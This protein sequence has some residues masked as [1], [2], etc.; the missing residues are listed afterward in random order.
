MPP[1]ST[2]IYSE[3]L[4]LFSFCLFPT[5]TSLNLKSVVFTMSGA[6]STPLTR[7]TPPTPESP[8]T[9]STAL[10]KPTVSTSTSISSVATS[11]ASAPADVVS[12]PVPPA[13]VAHD[14]AP[15]TKIPRSKK[16]QWFTHT[17]QVCATLIATVTTL[18][19][20]FYTVRT[21]NLGVW[22]YDLAAWTANKDYCEFQRSFEASLRSS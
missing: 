10:P 20:I 4:V 3:S 7:A 19:V 8:S 15:S 14:D 9:S 11:S 21:Y 1:R 13:T 17:W 16:W 5:N 2:R 22:T 12:S 6:L 18:M